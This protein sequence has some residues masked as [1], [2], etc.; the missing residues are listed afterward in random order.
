MTWTSK[1]I[2]HK[3]LISASLCVRPRLN[4]LHQS[5]AEKIQTHG[6]RWP[7]PHL[8]TWT[9]L[10]TSGMWVR[11]RWILTSHQRKPIWLKFCVTGLWNKT[12]MFMF[13]FISQDNHE[14]IL[15]KGEEK[16]RIFLMTPCIRAWLIFREILL[17]EI[18][19]WYQIIKE[20]LK[21]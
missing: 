1:G 5:E 10:R 8:L 9:L 21:I 20:I 15:K 7:Q 13:M 17:T 16:S 2:Q 6:H 3:D 19:V 14:I 4:V 18:K 11:R 12:Q